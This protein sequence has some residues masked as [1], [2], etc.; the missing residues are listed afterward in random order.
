M[1]HGPAVDRNE[2][3]GSDQNRPLTDAGRQKTRRVAAAL[4]SAY[5]P[6]LIITSRLLRAQETAVIVQAASQKNA[7]AKEHKN[8]E[9]VVVRGLEPEVG[10]D[11]WQK[12]F[13]H[14]LHQIDFMPATIW[15]VGHEPSISRILQGYLR[16]QETHASP[17]SFK[18]SGVA[19]LR[20]ND[21]LTAEGLVA[22]VPPKL[23]TMILRK[24]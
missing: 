22:F 18:K 6:D 3:Q 9:L 21:Q 13:K 15:A 12:D 24:G 10:F 5:P 1:R 11:E 2:W 17:I 4:V 8:H 19:V 16:I 14:Q 23:I 7:R 20:L